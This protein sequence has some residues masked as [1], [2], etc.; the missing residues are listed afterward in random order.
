MGDRIFK[1][2]KTQ[3]NKISIANI[4]LTKIKFDYEFKI[5]YILNNIL[6]NIEIEIY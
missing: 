5:S 6:F 3:K 2:K 4:S 1:K